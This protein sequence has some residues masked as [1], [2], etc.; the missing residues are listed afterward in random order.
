MTE[1]KRA[2]PSVKAPPKKTGMK[3][4]AF[5]IQCFGRVSFII[6][7]ISFIFIFADNS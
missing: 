7:F 6:F 1:A 3:I 4:N 2:E 5:F